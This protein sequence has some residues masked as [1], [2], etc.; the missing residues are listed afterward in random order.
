MGKKWTL[1][2]DS[3]SKVGPGTVKL[4]GWFSALLVGDHPKHL[5]PVFKILP[6]GTKRN[7]KRHPKVKQFWEH[8]FRAENWIVSVWGYTQYE[9]KVRQMYEVLKD[10]VRLAK[11][12]KIDWMKLAFNFFNYGYFTVRILCPQEK[13]TKEEEKNR[14]YIWASR[15]AMGFKPKCRRSIGK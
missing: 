12:L 11:E 10:A 1:R 7:Y 14:P 6:K 4:L 3:R 9:R 15:K 13:F 5:P 2:M 8:I